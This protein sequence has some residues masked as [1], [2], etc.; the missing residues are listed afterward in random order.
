MFPILSL[1]LIEAVTDVTEVI[2]V[3][4]L[5]ANSSSHSIQGY[6]LEVASRLLL[7]HRVQP[8]QGLLEHAI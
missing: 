5:S 1:L 2:E 3:M 7:H 8:E 4:V 6:F